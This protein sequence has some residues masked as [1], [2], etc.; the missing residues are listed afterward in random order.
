MERKE[1]EGKKILIVDDEEIVS[2][3]LLKLLKSQ[4]Y[5]PTIAKSG[6]EAI[7]RVKEEDFD[8]LIVDVRMPGM[9]GI[10][11]IKEI[12]K[13]LEESKRKSIPEVVITGYADLDKYQEALDLEV[14]DYLYKPFD[15]NEFL[16]IVKRNI[17]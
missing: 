13:I 7:E 12:R 2:K 15:N 14:K 16:K 11:M 17:G 1:T 9:D 6:K 5:Q 4:G 10:E 3:S 8:L